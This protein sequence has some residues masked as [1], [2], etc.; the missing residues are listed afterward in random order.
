MDCTNPAS[1]PI[2]HPKAGERFAL[3]AKAQ[4]NLEYEGK[5]WHERLAHANEKAVAELGKNEKTGVNLNIAP[6]EVACAECTQAKLPAS[7][8]K[9]PLVPTGTKL[10]N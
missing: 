1:D 2:Y 5:L 9:Y 6:D 7:S 8:K 4:N 3:I 10:A